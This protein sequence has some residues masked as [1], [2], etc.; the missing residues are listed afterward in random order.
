VLATNGRLHD[1]LLDLVAGLPHA[2]DFAAL[3]RDG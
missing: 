2:R 1:A 3:R